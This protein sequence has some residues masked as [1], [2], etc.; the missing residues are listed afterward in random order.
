MFQFAL[1]QSA[2]VSRV[3]LSAQL[4]CNLKGAGMIRN[5][6]SSH[7]VNA[8]QCGGALIQAFEIHKSHK[9]TQL[10]GATPFKCEINPERLN[11]QLSNL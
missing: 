8:L 10:S 4:E 9:D 6:I 1:S 11:A 7:A 3:Q 2:G 5:T